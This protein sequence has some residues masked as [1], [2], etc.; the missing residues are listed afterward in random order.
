[1]ATKTEER[2]AVVVAP[3]RLYN[4]KEKFFV[5]RIPELGL[6]AFGKTLDETEA[7]VKQMFGVYV[8]LHRRH[9]DLEKKLSESGLTWCWEKDYKG[10]KKLEGVVAIDPEEIAA[11][12]HGDIGKDPA[13]LPAV[14]ELQVA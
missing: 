5:T 9:G 4:K 6:S 13:W 2:V 8:R 10:T 3:Q 7:K 12:F 1:M 14:G 11:C